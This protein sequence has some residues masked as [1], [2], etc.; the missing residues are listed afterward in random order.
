MAG[1]TG[2]TKIW[3]TRAAG[4]A[5]GVAPARFRCGLAAVLVL[6]LCLQGCGRART[7]AEGDANAA[8]TNPP[9]LELVDVPEGEFLMGCT[10]QPLGYLQTNAMPTRTVRLSAFAIGRYPVSVHQYCE[11]LNDAGYADAYVH[12]TF[13]KDAAQGLRGPWWPRPGRA[14]QPARVTHT[15]A[16]AF[17]AWASKAKFEGKVCRLPTEAEWEY[18]ARG[19]EGRKYP[20]G[21]ATNKVHTVFDPIGARPELATPEGVQDLN[22]PVSQ[23]CLD[24]DQDT[25]ERLG[26]NNPVNM[27]ESKRHIV[28]GGP[29]TRMGFINEHMV[30]PPA[31]RRFAKTDRD[32]S[33][34]PSGFRVVVTDRSHPLAPK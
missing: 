13:R 18:V 34:L 14:S 32:T 33:A 11:F 9:P 15:G 27:A 28:R 31:W 24:F 20:W 29:L 1:L 3:W 2:W 19:K 23:W 22:G 16:Q 12:K 7:S 10:E 8:L 4:V 6:A 5:K 26:T 17:C 30:P 25:Y 21:N